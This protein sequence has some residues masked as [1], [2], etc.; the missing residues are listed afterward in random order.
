M[1][2]DMKDVVFD[3]VPMFDGGISGAANRT[4]DR[5]CGDWS[6]NFCQG[7]GPSLTARL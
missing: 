4:G 1:G 2:F 5:P 3:P 6:A 7:L